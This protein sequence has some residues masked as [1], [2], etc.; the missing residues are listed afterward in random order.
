MYPNTSGS[1]FAGGLTSLLKKI[2]FSSLLE[3]T[4]KT[5]NVINQAIPVYYQVKPMVSNLGTI[6]KIG[7]IVREPEEP[8]KESEEKSSTL[9]NGSPIFYI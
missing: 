3:G 8:K 7:K 1:L 5:L 6:R 9:K 4:S 2:N